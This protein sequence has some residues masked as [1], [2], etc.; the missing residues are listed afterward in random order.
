MTKADLAQN[1]VDEMSLI[2]G[3]EAREIVDQFFEEI[4]KSLIQG[5]E[6]KLSGLGCFHLKDKNSRPGRNPKTGKS[7]LISKRRVVSFS[8]SQS[9]RVEVEKSTIEKGNIQK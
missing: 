2:K 4:K 6:V 9:L 5:M 3:K 1:L 8:C 7:V